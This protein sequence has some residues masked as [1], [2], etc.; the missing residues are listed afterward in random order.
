MTPLVLFGVLWISHPEYLALLTRHAMGPKLITCSIV[1][2]TIGILWIRRLVRIEVQETPMDAI[3]IALQD[4]LGDSGGA[5][6]L[7]WPWRPPPLSR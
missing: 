3:L 6:I 1:M 7:S 2:G 5:G 4:F